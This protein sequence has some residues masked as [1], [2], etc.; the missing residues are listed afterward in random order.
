MICGVF[1]IVCA[2]FLSDNLP[3]IYSQKDMLFW[4]E[5]IG[6]DIFREQC[7]TILKLMSKVA[8]NIAFGHINLIHI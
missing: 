2:D 7:V 5:K 4:R 3:F 1:T 8:W 6:I